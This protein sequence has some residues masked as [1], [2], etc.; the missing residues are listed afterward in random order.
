MGVRS[1]DGCL[2]GVNTQYLDGVAEIGPS[3]AQ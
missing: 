1:Q 2:V 3:M